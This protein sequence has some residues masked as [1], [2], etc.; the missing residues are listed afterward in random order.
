MELTHDSRSRCFATF[1]GVLWRYFQV[2]YATPIFHPLS[3]SAVALI[4]IPYLPS[5]MGTLALTSVIRA[6]ITFNSDRP[7]GQVALPTVCLC[8]TLSKVQ[9]SAGLVNSAESYKLRRYV[10]QNM[11]P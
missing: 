4:P 3:R 2:S 11:C 5:R 7:D 1:D 10:I 6:D 9:S 8:A